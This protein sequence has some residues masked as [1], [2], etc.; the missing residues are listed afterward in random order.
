VYVWTEGFFSFLLGFLD[1]HLLEIARTLLARL[2]KLATELMEA[3][4]PSR[5]RLL[6]L[7][8]TVVSHRFPCAIRCWPPCPANPG[9]RCGRAG[10]CSIVETRLLQNHLLSLERFHLHL[11]LFQLRL[12]SG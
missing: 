4:E 8:V 12:F 1:F 5:V 10:S 7:R 11:D 2:M 3:E 9:H 6:P